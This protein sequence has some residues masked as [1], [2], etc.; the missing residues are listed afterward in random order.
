MSSPA[1]QP[2]PDAPTEKGRVTASVEGLLVRHRLLALAT[3]A[4]VAA[5]ILLLALGHVA[6]W[7]VAG[8]VALLVL[9]LLVVFTTQRRTAILARRVAEADGTQRQLAESRAQYEK[10]QLL[11]RDKDSLV[12]LIVH[13]MRSPISATILS[14]EFLSEQL[15]RLPNAESLLEATEDAM[16]AS[17]NVSDMIS[18]ILDTAKLEEGRITLHSAPVAA[19]DLLNTAQEQG[20]ARARRRQVH[21]DIE[22]M[23]DDL[24]VVA[25]PRLFPRLMENLVS[26][27]LRHTPPEGR[28][29]MQAVRQGGEIV[30]AVHNSGAPIAPAERE[31]IFDKFQQGNGETRRLSGWGLGLYFCRLVAEAHGGRIRVED[32]PGWSTS[33]IIRLPVG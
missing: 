29:L 15:K 14:L 22:V 25:D 19:R 31:K 10:L 17:T 9:T 12:Q 32:I 27:A 21:M 24:K 8:T 2:A 11:Q 33:F 26:N 3:G 16:T 13:D 1:Q 23:P 30:I 4:G 6:A 7:T 20:Q 18:Q 28:I 5:Q